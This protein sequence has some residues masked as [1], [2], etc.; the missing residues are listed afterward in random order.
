M[1]FL[2]LKYLLKMHYKI[3]LVMQEAKNILSVSEIFL[4][5]HPAEEDSG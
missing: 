3:L 4:P 2:T 1:K 5:Y